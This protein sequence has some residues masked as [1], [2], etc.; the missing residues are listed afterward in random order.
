LAESEQI[1]DNITEALYERSLDGMVALEFNAQYVLLTMSGSLLFDSGRV[2]LK[3]DAERVLTQVALIIQRYAAGDI[4]IEGHTDNV[5]MGGGGKYE[6]NDELSAGRA[7]SVYEFLMAHT[8]LDRTR[9]IHAGRG[10]YLPI[11][12]NGTEA[13]RAMNRRVEI[14]IYNSLSSN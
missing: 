12:D 3:D 9:V 10:E 4:Q 13:G 11:A 14:K 6:N 7:Y 5:P 8:A 2:D 1:A